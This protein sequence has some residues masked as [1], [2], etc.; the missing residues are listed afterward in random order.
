M[1]GMESDQKIIEKY[2]K[3]HCVEEAL[4]EVLNYVVTERPANPFTAIAKAIELK[5][6]PEILDVR[7]FA[8]YFQD[9]NAVK[10]VLETNI[11]QFVGE[12]F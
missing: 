7:F 2:L 3:D 6:F 5:T 11:G 8:M 10:A 4:D 9:R 12:F 1:E